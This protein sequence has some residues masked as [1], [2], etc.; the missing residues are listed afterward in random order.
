MVFQELLEGK[1]F[2]IEG[3]PLP[4]GAH[5]ESAPTNQVDVL[6]TG[7][8]ADGLHQVPP[9]DADSSQESSPPS[10]DEDAIS[11][12][13]VRSSIDLEKTN[14][15]ARRLH[16]DARSSEQEQG[17]NIL[18]AT[19]GMLKW[20]EKPGEVT[21]R[22]A[23]LVMLPIRI[24]ELVRLGGFSISSDGEDPEFNQ[25]LSERLKRDFD[26]D[27]EIE[28]DDSSVLTQVYAKVR[29]A[30]AAQAGWEV[31]D[32]VHVGRFRFHKLR[33]FKDLA[34][35]SDIASGHEIIQ[36][37]AIEGTTIRRL[38]DGIPSEEALDRI[39]SPQ[40]SFTVL[41]ADA[42]QLRAIQAVT[43]GSHIII[44][45]PPGTGKSQTI[46]NVIAECIA[47]DKTVLFVSEKAAAIEVVHRRLSERG[48]GDY[49]LM[50]HSH[51]ANK[52]DII[53][54]L[55]ERLQVESMPATSAHEER[56]LKQLEE[57]RKH[58]NAY[59]E[60]LHHP[61]APLGESAYWA[62]GEIAS[63]HEMPLIDADPPTVNSLTHDQLDG[64]QQQIERTSRYASE[65]KEGAK[66]PWS[67]IREGELT[68][69]DRNRLQRSLHTIRET[70][71]ELN[72]IGH[73][74][75][76]ELSLPAPTTLHDI[77][78]LRRICVELPSDEI[79]RPE[80][81]DRERIND[82]LQ[83]ASD[84]MVR[85]VEISTQAE[86]L[87]TEYE[88]VVLEI[89]GSEAIA[90]Y[91]K[92]LIVRLLS[93][94]YRQ[95]RS[96]MR[97]ASKKGSQ[98][99]ASEELAALRQAMQIN[100]K[101]RWFRDNE[102]VISKSL[103]DADYGSPV[104]NPTLF[105]RRQRSI[106][107]VQGILEAVP[108]EDMSEIVAKVCEPGKARRIA[109]PRKQLEAA[110]KRL[111][112]S[113]QTLTTFIDDAAMRAGLGPITSGSISDL[114]RWT[115]QR[116]ARFDDLE[117]WLRARDSLAYSH[118][119]GLGSVVDAL[120]R[121][122]IVRNY[123]A[124]T[125]RRLLLT[126]WLDHVYRAD[127]QL[128]SFTGDDQEE[129]IARFR[130]L[131][132][133]SINWAS[134]RIR[135]LQARKSERF[136]GSGDGEP[137]ILQ[138]EA[139]KRRRHMPLRRLF[140]RIS[141]LL[142]TLKPCLMMSPLSVA[143][144]LPADRYRFDVVIFDE[145]SQVRPYDAIGAIMR[146]DQLVVAGD[147]KQL[148][149]TSFFDRTSDEDH[150]DEQDIRDLESI[151]DALNAKG[152]MSAPLL[153][154]Y[155]SRHE[156]L[157][158]YSNH[159]FY[160][161]RLITFPSPSAERREGLGVRLEYVPN[162]L[163]VEERDQVTATSTR[164]NRTE[165]RRV[166]E[167]VVMHTRIRPEQSLGVVTLG[168][169]QREIV[170]EEVQAARLLDQSLDE[171]FNPEKPDYFFVKALEQVQGDERDVMMVCIGFGKNERGTLSHNF[172][173]INRDGGER[174]LNVL[175]TRARREV[176]V[177]SSIRGGDIDLT[178]TKGLGPRLLKNYLDFAEQGPRALAAEVTESNG[179]YESPFE[180]E[181]GEAL[182]RAGYD[183]R[184]QIGCSG[185]R[186]DLAIVDPRQSG[187]FILG[188][189]CDG[190]TYHQ[191]KTARDRD[192]LRQEILEG[193]GWEIHRVWSTNWIRQP[194]GEL[195]R[196][197]AR[198][199]ALLNVNVMETVE[200]AP[201]PSVEE[202][203]PPL[204]RLRLYE[205]GLALTDRPVN[206][207][208]GVDSTIESAVAVLTVPYTSA[209]LSQY[210]KGQL[211]DMPA[212]ALARIVVNCVDEEGPI[213]E[214]LLA[215]RIASAWGFQRTGNRISQK[216]SGAIG[217]AIR[218]GN[219]TARGEFLW[220]A[221]PV[222]IV[223]RGPEPN[224]TLRTVTHIAGEELERAMTLLLERS[225]SLSENEL[226]IQTARLF[227]NQRTGSEISRRVRD[228]LN[229]AAQRGI[230]EKRANRYQLPR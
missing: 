217:S 229:G 157:I 49:C 104:P 228:V 172:G 131:D 199:S 61:R 165:A 89:A 175:V 148:P 33:M 155:R 43:R 212:V 115:D 182:K 122:D 130:E 94:A 32:E 63:L 119:S 196:L 124:G 20:Q 224:G 132:R 144:F 74:L 116:I 79:L 146:G 188:V 133:L 14:R 160:G 71:G 75:A 192:R 111:D 80:W 195:D 170:E 40:D 109:T 68:L 150:D 28:L 85:A 35:H 197:I 51:K 214:D 128:R 70:L 215:R 222:E 207:S 101:L 187:R 16:T 76:E 39:V 91:E 78:R 60:A 56:G 159:H 134:Q 184:S 149:P 50:L 90:S 137:G 139:Q 180:A 200:N 176:I 209:E 9:E 42:S 86:G 174:R 30:V 210:A 4:D 45:G 189:E 72:D 117:T 102:R 7:E 216:V 2:F 29:A 87:F 226:V 145:A 129:R 34:E 53:Y 10:D 223:P 88:H 120:V 185:Y 162:G 121:G 99:S 81:F 142:P 84:A 190:R 27:L 8:T 58:L 37:L 12:G 105:Q 18:F 141:N 208:S 103:G 62:H 1:S 82:R 221:Y 156:D 166:A 204:E 107:A 100:V 36:A 69:A 154:H 11:P 135:R 203:E 171:F 205:D 167:L 163:Y 227:G 123:W 178:R 17:I 177:I 13:K 38:D 25:T 151:L 158:A 112:E 26:L 77:L 92:N 21:W 211:L 153:W 152:M 127:D 73:V 66:H 113:M 143:Q 41:D 22:Y 173:P 138:H 169:K 47:A 126:H 230:I 136:A 202:Q 59:A 97:L 193:L 98:R 5:G 218:Q 44:Q 93:P 191:S 161:N 106:A 54:D 183:V 110:M 186:I 48:L 194:A 181:V 213:H 52:R 118:R 55:G 219:I 23:P 15:V 6:P 220:P 67:C 206:P 125:F 179:E 108:L 140:S 225:F 46:A 201:T 147:S 168:M 114:Y 65:L 24:E 64:W 3:K 164:V 198:V 83:L 57:T 31:L 19:F 95:Y 96:R